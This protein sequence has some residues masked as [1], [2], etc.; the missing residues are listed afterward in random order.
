VTAELLGDATLAAAA[1]AAGAISAL[2]LAEA[3]LAAAGAIDDLAAIASLQPERARAAARQSDERRSA[4][5][6]RGPLDGIPVLLKDNVAERGLPNRAGSV[7]L[8]DVPA[9]ADATVT[10][11]LRA[12]GA[13]LVGRTNMHELAW[14]GTTDNPHLGTCRN[15]YD[16]DRVPAGSSGGTAA[17]VAAGVCAVGIGTDTGGSIRL[18]ASVT[19]LTGLRPSLGRVP[20]TGV[21]PLAWTL[22]TVGPIGRSAAECRL[23]LDAVDGPD[24][25]DDGC[26]ARPDTLAHLLGRPDPWAGLRVGVVGDVTL[27]GLQPGV[28]AAVRG[29]LDDAASW[30]AHLVDVR[31]PYLDELVDA[32]VV[33]NAAEAS[34]VHAAAL[35]AHPERIGAD[36]RTLLEAGSRFTAVDYL[37]AQRLRTLA[38]DALARTW[39][40]VDVLVI[41]TLA[42]TAPRI[43]ERDIDLGGRTQD[44]LV[45]NMRYTA[46]ASLTGAPGLSFPCGLDAAGLPV[47]AQLVGPAW[48]DRA[49]LHL[50]DDVQT[51]TAHHRARPVRRAA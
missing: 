13:V 14:G 24:G 28:A 35:R 31:L 10:A 17:A 45:A 33:L 19:N 3:A 37:Q 44:V 12:A 50:V 48:S 49:L 47:G 7:L 38:R 9:P 18:P 23:V 41:P 29:L 11:R 51:R 34:A 22:D 46:L 16:P 27:D 39:A 42:F 8:P 40:Q 2:E 4:G 1:L 26:V 25:L 30:G 36:V 15:P 43:G 21:V 6:A 5:H 20:T 32:L